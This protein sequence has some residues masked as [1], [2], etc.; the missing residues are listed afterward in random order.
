MIPS[1]VYTSLDFGLFRVVRP[2]AYQVTSYGGAALAQ[3]RANALTT[4]KQGQDV[5]VI[6]VAVL[7]QH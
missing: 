2:H 4:G 5:T 6:T 7:S 1:L 3:H